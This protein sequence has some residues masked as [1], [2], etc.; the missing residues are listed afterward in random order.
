MIKQRV[1]TLCSAVTVMVLDWTR[2]LVAE[3]E[4]GLEM[5]TGPAVKPDRGPFMQEKGCDCVF[6]WLKI[7]RLRG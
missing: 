2:S 7:R 6:W 3:M 1:S 4:N 5:G